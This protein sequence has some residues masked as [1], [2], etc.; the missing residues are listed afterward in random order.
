MSNPDQKKNGGTPVEGPEPTVKHQRSPLWVFVTA[1][2]LLY[3]GMG[4]LADRAGGFNNQVYEPYP[5][6]AYVK[7]AHPPQGDDPVAR[8]KKVFEA[9]GCGGCHG[10]DGG[11]TPGVNPPL[12]GSEWV[13]AEG[14]NRLIRIVLNGLNGPI[15][16]KGQN[17][18]SQ[19]PAMGDGLT[20]REIADLLSFLRKSWGN[21]ASV[22]TE[23]QVKPIASEVR[24]KPQWKP[25]DLLALP[26]K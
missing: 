26:D 22:V 25:A 2:V 21:D 13:K 5:S 17:Y 14:P 6:L 4:F 16:V 1:G 8:G 3:A 11:G 7:R 12:A 18:N 20:D 23:T 15:T 24:G 10:A 19:M 9:R